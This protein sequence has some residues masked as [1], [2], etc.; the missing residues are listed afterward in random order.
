MMMSAFAVTAPLQRRPRTVRSFTVCRAYETRPQPV[1]AV[2]SRRLFEV[3]KSRVTTL[4]VGYNVGTL[5]ARNTSGS[6]KA[7]VSTSRTSVDPICDEK[8]VVLKLFKQLALVGKIFSVFIL[9]AVS[10][11]IISIARSQLAVLITTLAAVIG[12]V[13]LHIVYQHLEFMMCSVASNTLTPSLLSTRRPKRIFMVRHGE[14]QGN[15]DR[16]LYRVLPDNKLQLTEKGRRQAFEVGK[17]LKEQIGDESVVFYV[18]PYTRTRQTLEEM[19]EGG[20]FKS[21][22]V[23][24][25]PHLREQEFGNFQDPDKFEYYNREREVCGWFYH[26]VP[27]G[28]SGA[29]LYTRAAFFLE[30]MFRDIDRFNRA[31]Q[32][33]ENIVIVSHGLTMR[34]LCM[35]YFNWSVEHLQMV[36]PPG[37]AELWKLSR[38]DDLTGYELETD[39]LLTPT[40][41]ENKPAA[42]SNPW[43]VISKKWQ[44]GLW[45][46]GRKSR[47][48]A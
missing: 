11:V 9:L 5:K 23:H 27:G 19:L 12:A 30:T 45:G 3:L 39:V 17:N 20:S 8:Q 14:S 26:R 38:E 16:T 41:R 43:E 15:V 31:G 24:E 2:A 22:S 46:S 44:Q 10:V 1:R 42:E 7:A 40:D 4:L 6:S 28:E 48:P 13:A 33:I 25:N 21:F 29:D 47:R 34:L 37:N 18:S 35:R 36:R 32:P